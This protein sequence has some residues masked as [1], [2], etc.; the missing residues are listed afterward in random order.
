MVSLTLISVHIVLTK[1]KVNRQFLFSEIG[2]KLPR[3]IAE[4]ARMGNIPYIVMSMLA[5]LEI[6][7]PRKESEQILIGNFFHNLDSQLSAEVEK[8]ELLN[9]LKSAFLQKMFI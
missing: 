3:K 4:E 1:F 9:Q 8:L 2:N 5:D 7:V 6:Q